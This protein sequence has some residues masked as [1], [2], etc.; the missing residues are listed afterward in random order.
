MRA[1]C[2]NGKTLS[3]IFFS[4]LDGDSTTYVSRCGNKRKNA[5]S[6]YANLLS[7]VYSAHPNY[8]ELIG[9]DGSLRQC[10]MKQFFTK[11][12]IGTSYRWLNLV[13]T[14][15]L[16]FSTVKKKAFRGNIRHDT[17]SLST[18]MRYL[19]RITTLFETKISR[20][21]PNNFRLSS[22]AGTHIPLISF[23]F[24]LSTLAPTLSD[25]IRVC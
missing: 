16:P 21:L 15:L 8:T 14:G 6:S 9:D 4:Q 13:I 23:L 19:P 17:I 20:E 2:G 11:T 18:F 1:T 24:S 25:T 3:E 12:N 7:H 22:M 5:G 10:K